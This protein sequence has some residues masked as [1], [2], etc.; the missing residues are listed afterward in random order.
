MKLTCMLCDK[1]DHIDD[2]SLLAKR[3]RNHPLKTYLCTA[4]KDRITEK[5]LERRKKHHP[6]SAEEKAIH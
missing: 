2:D 1:V 5:T 6:A 3:Y 4:C